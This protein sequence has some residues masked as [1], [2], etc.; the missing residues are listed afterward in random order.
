MEGYEQVLS[1]APLHAGATY[2]LGV[3][4]QQNGDADKA[5]RLFRDAI[6]LQEDVV[7]LSSLAA[8]LHDTHRLPEAEALYRRILRLKPDSAEAYCNLGSLLRTTGRLDDAEVAYR[9]SISLRPDLAESHYNLANVLEEMRRLSEAEAGYRMAIQIRPDYP[10][11]Y[12]NLGKLLSASN[13]LD[14]AEAAFR[15]A[16]ELAPDGGMALYNLGNV[17]RAAYKASDAEAA[18]RQ[19]LVL[20]PNNTD[21]HFNLGKLLEELGR[22]SEA[23]ASYRQAVEVGPGSPDPRWNLALL[24]L[25]VGRYPEAWPYYESRHDGN[26]ATRRV[27]PPELPFPQ[28]QGEPLA[29]RSILVCAEQGFGD[30]IQFSRYVPLLKTL[31]TSRIVLLCYPEL[32]ALFRTLVGVDAIVTDPASIGACDCWSLLLSLPRHFATTV[33]TIPATLPYLHAEPSRIDDWSDKLPRTGFKV[34]LV[35]KGNAGHGNDSNR[36]LPGLATL[37]PLWQVPGVVFVSLQTGIRGDEAAD[38]RTQPIVF[39]GPDLRDFADTAAVVSQLD[40]VI[41]VDTAAAHLVG[42]LGKRCWL[43]LPYSGTDWRWMLD[44]SDSPWYPEVLK[45]FRQEAP[46]DWSKTVAAVAAALALEAGNTQPL[47]SRLGHSRS[48][49][50]DHVFYVHSPITYSIAMAAIEH[51]GIASPIVIGG[52]GIRGGKVDCTVEDDGIWSVPRTAALMAC[53]AERLSPGARM[54][55]YIPHTAFLL[56]RLITMSTRVAAISFL[57]EG[58][59]SAQAPLLAQAMAPAEIDANYLTSTLECQGLVDAWQIDRDALS[60]INNR[61]TRVFDIRSEKY[62]GA[63]AHSPDAFQGMSGVIKLTLRVDERRKPARLA[64]FFGIRNR[65]GTADQLEQACR[66]VTDLVERLLEDDDENYPFL[67]KLHPVDHGG[68]PRWFYERLRELGGSYTDYCHRHDVDA[69]VEPALINFDHYYIFGRTAQSKYV[70]M[71]LG[72]QR[73]TLFEI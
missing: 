27:A 12:N 50:T 56:G 30:C 39:L 9:L 37:E 72:S 58:Y 6:Q 41:S 20:D 22:L 15:R 10:S 69:N 40:L 45:L 68:L 29:G 2:L 16:H 71:L 65:Y 19:A 55:L 38:A 60:D 49:V 1:M 17:F 18:Y 8:L 32:E 21:A 23:E 66:I 4:H 7:F 3:V 36:S 59:T 52:R 62:Q 51:L 14:E 63:F 54:A 67:V 33:A 42:A 28:W 35:W 25:R 34:G 31:G 53:I 61:T 43:L 13:R 26:R 57:E 44:R 48:G 5:E 46:S 73:M 64:T 70:E 11:A 24:L 47:A